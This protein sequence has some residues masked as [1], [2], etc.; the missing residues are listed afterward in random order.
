MADE[1]PTAPPAG[2]AAAA[3]AWR[4]LMLPLRYDEAEVVLLNKVVQ[5]GRS[6][7]KTG[8]NVHR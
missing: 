1:P 6:F 7:G 4:G 2:R 8:W 5:L 3:G